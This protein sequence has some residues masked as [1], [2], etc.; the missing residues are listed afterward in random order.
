MRSLAGTTLAGLLLVACSFRLAE[1]ENPSAE[2]AIAWN[3]LIMQT[4]VAEDGLLTL[5]GVRTAA[6]AHLAMHDA[7]SSIEGRYAAYLFSEDATDAD[8]IVAASQAGFAVAVDQYPDQ[9]EA[10]EA[11]RWSWMARAGS[12]ADE[13]GVELGNRAAAAILD[14]RQGDGWSTEAEYAWHP[15]GPGVYAEFNEHS[16]TP[17]GFVFG[18]G[19]G[20]ARPF[21][22]ERPDQFVSPPPP[23]IDSPEYTEAYLEV[24]S[25]GAR[26]SSTRTADQTHLALWWKDFVENSHNRLARDLVERES[27]DLVDAN[28]LFALISAGTFDAYVSSFHNKFVYNHWRPYTAIRW[29]EHDGNPDTDPDVEWTNTHDHTYAFPSYPSAHGTA[30][31]AAMAAFANTFGD[32]YAFTMYTPVVDAAGPFSGKMETDPPSRSFES[33]SDAA[34]ECTMSRLYLGIHFRYDSVEGNRL[35]RQVGDVAVG[36]LARR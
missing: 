34:L 22:L 23:D 13:A 14:D 27:L 16:G 10:F 12:G 25:V 24:K 8:P 21:M 17:E 36:R 1:T 20:M 19:W 4:A 9:R 30:C 32:D 5:K 6:M 2:L 3:E 35:G 31:A 28:R 7:L 11:L 33:F 15:M 29:A 18:A 26:E